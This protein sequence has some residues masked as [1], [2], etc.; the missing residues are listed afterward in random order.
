MRTGVAIVVVGLGGLA[1]AAIVAACSAPGGTVTGP[2]VPIEVDARSGTDAACANGVGLR[3]TGGC[4]STWL[5]AEAGAVALTCARDDAGTR[6]ACTDE[7]DA[8]TIFTPDAEPCDDG[9]AS[10]AL[11]RARC[12]WSVP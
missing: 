6:C 4:R 8:S 3:F 7:T 11:A 5:C 2:I 1:S 10:A 12:G 9:G